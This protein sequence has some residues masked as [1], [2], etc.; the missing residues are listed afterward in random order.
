MLPLAI[1][2]DDNTEI[3]EFIKDVFK[4]SLRTITAQNGK[5]GI[6]KI[7]EFN[8]DLIIT[9]LMMP[10]MDGMEMCKIIRKNI[11]TST[12]PI[13]MLTANSEK[14][15]ELYSLK[16]DIDAF[17]TKPFDSNMLLLKAIQLVKKKD[18]EQIRQRIENISKPK[19]IVV[20]SPDEKFLSLI[21]LAIEE[22]IEDSDLNVTSLCEQLQINNKQMYRKLK[23]LTGLSPV[24]Y[25][26]SIRLK[27]AAMLL[28]QNKFTVS[29]VLYMVGF[30]NPSYFSKC[31][32]AEFGKTPKQYA[33]EQNQNEIK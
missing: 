23:Q 8:P 13:I 5:E 10:E 22:R 27:K 21:T 18:N 32:Q 9:D 17:I 2:I 20:E 33:E 4:G 29:E 3:T 1:I 31:F 28:N 19:E 15:N 16:L 14:N 24:E 7:E 12:T 11:R 6:S 25:I 26:K 30:S